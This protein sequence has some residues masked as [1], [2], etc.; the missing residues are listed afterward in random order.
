[1]PAH[2]LGRALAVALGDGGDDLLMLGEAVMVGLGLDLVD[3]QPPPGDRA[4]NRAQR[5]EERDQER[6]LRRLGDGAVQP[7]V[8]AFILPPSR[9]R[10]AAG[11]AGAHLRYLR[12]RGVEGRHA[13]DLGLDQEARAHHLGGVGAPD[14]RID[15]GH[16]RDGPR[17]DEGALS[18]M[19]P[20]LP[21]GL[22]HRER[23]P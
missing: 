15:V 13:R 4:P 17:A 7:V 20:D 1:M 19:A 9:G 10:A 18:D 23:L 3:A 5:V 12:G 8:P 21:F 16:G 2:R 6:V 22:K 11:H 14:H